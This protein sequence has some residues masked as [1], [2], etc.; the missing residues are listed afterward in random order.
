MDSNSLYGFIKFKLK[1]KKIRWLG[2][3]FEIVEIKKKIILRFTRL[4]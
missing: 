4:Y 1:I 2:V 3:E